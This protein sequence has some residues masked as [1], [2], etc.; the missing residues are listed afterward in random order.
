MIRTNRR[1]TIAMRSPLSSTLHSDQE[2]RGTL[3]QYAI[4]PST[5]STPSLQSLIYATSNDRYP[6][7]PGTS[8]HRAKVEAARAAA[9]TKREMQKELERRE[10]MKRLGILGV[11]KKRIVGGINSTAVAAAAATNGVNSR[12]STPPA[13]SDRARR[14]GG[15]GG[16][17]QQSQISSTLPNAST[18]LHQVA[19]ASSSSSSST[20][21]T[22][23]PRTN[24]RN[25]TN[26]IDHNSLPVPFNA[27]TAAVVPGSPLLTSSG[28]IRRPASSSRGASPMP[29]TAA[30]GNGTLSSRVRSPIV[31]PVELDGVETLTR[32]GDGSVT[33][34]VG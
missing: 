15:G 30:N 18:G 4:P 20:T 24:G 7:A 27:A 34:I 14:G 22:R 3:T 1:K 25:I 6:G 26:A 31:A 19:S 29:L 10:E 33:S 28:R 12:F 23:Q 8:L 2:V 11:G 21:S 9:A 32:G 5:F 16:G 17:Q 13:V